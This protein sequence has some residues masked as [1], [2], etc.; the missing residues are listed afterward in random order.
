M[1]SDFGANYVSKT[2]ATNVVVL[3]SISP[4]ASLS[5]WDTSDVFQSRPQQDGTPP[6]IDPAGTRVYFLVDD[7]ASAN[8]THG[9]QVTVTVRPRYL[10]VG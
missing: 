6:F 10:V 5:L 8:I 1:P 7:S 4:V 2:S 3:D 9:G